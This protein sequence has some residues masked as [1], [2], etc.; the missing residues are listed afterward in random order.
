MTRETFEDIRKMLKRIDHLK[1]TLVFLKN[2]INDKTPIQLITS[3]KGYALITIEELP[4]VVEAY[5][6][7]ID[8]LQR[9]FERI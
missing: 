9:E 4:F 5:E 8:N 2:A 1:D 6:N 3:R 7:E